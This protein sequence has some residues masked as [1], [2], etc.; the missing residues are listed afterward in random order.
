MADEPLKLD[1]SFIVIHE[2]WQSM[3]LH[4][5][6][7]QPGLTSPSLHLLRPASVSLESCRPTPLVAT[8]LLTLNL[9]LRYSFL[10]ISPNQACGKKLKTSVMGEGTAPVPV[11]GWTAKS[12]I[13]ADNCQGERSGLY[14][15]PSACPFPGKVG[16]IPTWGI[17]P[18][19]NS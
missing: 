6:Q 3:P 7:T 19:V 10:P 17:S 12:S 15:S 13:S 2:A 16:I 9:P 4:L 14:V 11:T 1:C 18:T 5:P 8:P